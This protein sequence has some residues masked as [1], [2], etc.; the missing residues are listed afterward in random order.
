[1]PPS[2][3][4]NK[5]SLSKRSGRPPRSY[6]QDMIGLV[7]PTVHLR[8]PDC[9]LKLLLSLSFKEGVYGKGETSRQTPDDSYRLV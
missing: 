8:K 4:R 9:Q 2:G 5:M 3:I 7:V 6:N 1:M